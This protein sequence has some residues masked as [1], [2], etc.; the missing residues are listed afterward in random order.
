MATAN[1]PSAPEFWDIRF[2]EGRTPWDAGG[3][4]HELAKYL[5]GASAGGRVLI[6]G[7]GAAYEAV[8]FHEAGYEVIAIDFSPAA[9]AAARRTLGPL[10]G[11]AR[12][13]DFFLYDFGGNS[14]DVIYERAFLCSLPRNLWLRYV[15]RVSELLQ[16][17]GVL[18]GFFFFDAKESGP[19][20]GLRQGELDDLLKGRFV[21]AADEQACSS[22][23]VFAGRERWQ[24]WRRL[25]GVHSLRA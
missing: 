14:F 1:D 12:L 11:L 18:V 15:T 17:G 24:Q 9:V 20:F 25:E 2:R 10:Q 13:G 8:A 23:P 16:P 22:V 6:P 21:L 3:V 4:P 19:P 5:A 7:C